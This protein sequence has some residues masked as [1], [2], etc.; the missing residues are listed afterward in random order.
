MDNPYW[1]RGI[2]GAITVKHD[3]PSLIREAT[4]KLLNTLLERNDI[5]DFNLITSIFFSATT[6]LKS[7]CPAKAA[8][9]ELKMK[10]VPFMCYQEMFVK[11]SLPKTIR[12]M[13]HV[14]TTKSQA[15]V[16][17]VYLRKAES[18]RPD[19]LSSS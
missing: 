10:F 4:Q 6:D 12:I 11:K 13:V 17:H 16:K 9:E 2:R 15:E 5:N 3:D 19:L 8:R 14:H 1:L 7:L 18:L